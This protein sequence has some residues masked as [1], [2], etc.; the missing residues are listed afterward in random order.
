MCTFYKRKELDKTLLTLSYKP[1]KMKTGFDESLRPKEGG[2]R[3]EDLLMLPF[4]LN[5]AYKDYIWGGVKLRDQ[6]GK[7]GPTPLAESWELSAHPD[8]DAVIASGPLA[9]TRFSAFIKDNPAALG[10]RCPAGD[11]PVMV[12]LIDAAQ[13]LSVQ[14]HPDDAYGMRVEGERGKTE[15][16]YILDCEPGAFLYFGFE[17]EIS[18]DEARRRIADNTITE[19]LHKAPVHPGDVFFIAAGTVHAIGAGILLA[20]IQE[21]SNTTYRVYD[22]GRVGADGKPRPL[23]IDKAMQVARLAPASQDAPGAEPP[24]TVAGG[25]LRRLAGCAYFTADTLKLAGRYSH[26]PG[27]AS[28][29]SVL[30]LDGRAS[31]CCGDETLTLKKGGS[32]FVPADAP[33]FALDGEGAFLLTTV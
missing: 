5:P 9:G 13:N 8:G 25:T 27:N 10:S 6:F 20:E 12:K 14:V 23:H 1:D 19:V 4:L 31:L 21:N 18:A 28:F 30:C 22:F 11:F 17:R 7:D 24:R 32:A 2:G 26:A 3:K 15:M 16:W 29:V 33:E